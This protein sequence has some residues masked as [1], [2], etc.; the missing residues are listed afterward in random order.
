MQRRYCLLHACQQG[1]PTLHPTMQASYWAWQLI[2]ELAGADTAK[3][4]KTRAGTS[5]QIL[6]LKTRLLRD[7]RK[8]LLSLRSAP[9]ARS[10]TD[11]SGQSPDT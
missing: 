11:G 3:H 7:A 4:V 1:V 6:F 8:D 10:E 5:F 9:R 2:A